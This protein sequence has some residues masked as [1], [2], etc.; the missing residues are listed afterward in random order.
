MNSYPHRNQI[1]FLVGRYQG[2]RRSVSPGLH[3][4]TSVNDDS[5]RHTRALFGSG[6]QKSERRYIGTNNPRQLGNGEEANG[7]TGVWLGRSDEGYPAAVTPAELFETLLVINAECELF[8][9]YNGEQPFDEGS[10]LG[11]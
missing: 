8:L 4:I 10:V 5:E 6:L 2:V 9:T 11:W 7:I 3:H 1:I